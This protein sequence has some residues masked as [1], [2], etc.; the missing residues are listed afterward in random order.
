MRQFALYTGK[1]VLKGILSDDLYEHFLLFSV[2]V[3][4]L[5]CPFLVKEYNSYAADLLVHFVED[6]RKLYGD[7]FLVYNVHSLVHLASDAYVYGGLDE[8][9]AFPFENYL[10]Q[11]KKLIRSGRH[12]RSQ[13]VKR[14]N[15]ID[16][17]K[18]ELKRQPKAVFKTQ[19][20]N[21]AY[22]LSDVQCCEIIS[23][24]GENGDKER[25]VHCRIYE[26]LEPIFMHPCDSRIVV[27]KAHV[28]AH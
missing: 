11:L 27:Y 6:G 3:S 21:N 5:V 10:H 22:V 9:S 18:E 4:I 15:E 14:L 8:C 25:I 12:P 24:M 2:A 16:K 20:P 13:I 1:E 23:V 28:R 7:E 19:K 26:K 17:H